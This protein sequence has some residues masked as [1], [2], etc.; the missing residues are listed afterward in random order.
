MSEKD[1]IK[2]L[3]QL[4]TGDKPLRDDKNPEYL[5]STTDSE[6]LL[7][8]VQKEIHPRELALKELEKRGLN[9]EGRWIG[10]ERGR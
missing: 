5:F 10:F 9:K 2:Q 4:H 3:Q 8:I 7:K 6:L 1:K